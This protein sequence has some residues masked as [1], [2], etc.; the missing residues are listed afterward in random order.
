MRSNSPRPFQWKSSLVAIAAALVVA[1]IQNSCE[2]PCESSLPPEGTYVSEE[3]HSVGDFAI[4]TPT[5]IIEDDVVTVDLLF[6]NGG[7]YRISYVP[8]PEYYKK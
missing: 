1:L 5:F 4:A 7:H 3:D 2:G 8:T 6:E